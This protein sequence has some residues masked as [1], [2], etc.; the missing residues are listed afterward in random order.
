M[1]ASDEQL[2][3]KGDVRNL[4][5]QLIRDLASTA[6]DQTSVI[7]HDADESHSAVALTALT[8]LIS[9][10]ATYI[11]NDIVITEVCTASS[12]DPSIDLWLSYQRLDDM[13]KNNVSSVL[14]KASSLLVAY[15]T[16]RNEQSICSSLW[17][18]VLS[19]ISAEPT[20]GRNKLIELL[21]V[22]EKNLPSYLR[23]QDDELDSLGAK[24]I[25]DA[26]SGPD[27]IALSTAK[28]L[29]RCPGTIKPAFR[30]S[31]LNLVD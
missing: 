14:I 13:L 7:L 9:T 5:R 29:M 11:L 20:T 18:K 19:S 1:K 24:I 6:I 23:P 30:N 26:V 12:P 28:Q 16:Y 10:F 15:F 2:H 4:L 27:S 8:Y 17:A 25:S 22:A 31:L 3:D 21:P